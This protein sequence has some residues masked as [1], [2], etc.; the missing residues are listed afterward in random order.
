MRNLAARVVDQDVHAAQFFHRAVNHRLDL[1][2]VLDVGLDREPLAPQGADLGCSALAQRRV[3]VGD[4]DIGAEA[5]ERQRDPLA[6][7]LTAAGDDGNPVCQKR[8]GR[9]HV[10]SL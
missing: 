2:E 3:A 6:N 10:T 7:S 8:A 4:Y 1:F 5:G 9:I